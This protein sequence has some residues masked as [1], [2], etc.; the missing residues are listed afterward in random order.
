LY[1]ALCFR[2]LRKRAWSNA[3]LRAQF[4]KRRQDGH[5]RLQPLLVSMLPAT[6]LRLLQFIGF[7]G[8][9]QFGLGKQLEAA[10]AVT[11]SLRSTPLAQLLLASYYANQ[12]QGR[13]GVLQG[14]PEVGLRHLELSSAASRSRLVAAAVAMRLGDDVGRCLPGG[15]AGR[16][17]PAAERL[18]GGSNWSKATMAYIRAC[19]LYHARSHAETANRNR[20]GTGTGSAKPEPREAETGSGSEN[21]KAEAEPE[22][23]EAEAEAEAE[24]RN[25]NRKT[26]NARGKDDNL[27][28]QQLQS[29]FEQ[30]FHPDGA[31]VPKLCQRLAGRTLPLDK[32]AARREPKMARAVRPPHPAGLELLI[33]WGVCHLIEPDCLAGRFLPAV[34][35]ES[36]RL[37]EQQR[38]EREL[39][40][41]WARK[42]DSHPEDDRALVLLLK[43]ICLRR[44]GKRW[45]FHGHGIPQ[46]E[47]C[48]LEVTDT[49]SGR[50]HPGPSRDRLGLA[51]AGRSADGRPTGGRRPGRAYSP[52]WVRARSAWRARDPH[53]GARHGPG[54]ADLLMLEEDARAKAGGRRNNRGR[55][56]GECREPGHRVL[57][58]QE[59]VRHSSRAVAFSAAFEGLTKPSSA[60]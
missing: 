13:I 30:L 14:Q 42:R 38:A 47:Q 60:L 18:A 1:Q 12:A 41:Q 15:L 3:R 2:L 34:Q 19:F 33:V 31:Q 16:S 5:R 21:R 59:G 20:A 9:R 36:D 43:A 6:V 58:P 48:L 10:A 27:L 57:L 22:A 52:V 28:M 40:Q 23:A 8:D 53:E 29:M 4:E 55:D 17:C 7:S 26:G 46:A 25:R 54:A 35:A 44:L 39:Q 56:A 11:D 24:A 37:D 50:V 51:G 49:L 45:A 32:F